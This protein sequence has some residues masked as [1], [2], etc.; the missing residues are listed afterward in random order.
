MIYIG[1]DPGKKGGYSIIDGGNVTCAP[2]DDQ[3]FALDMRTIEHSQKECMAC[4]EKVGA[5]PGQGVTSM[6]SFGKSAGYIEGVLSATLI[7]YQLVAPRKWK[8]EFGLLHGS[9]QQSIEVCRMLFPAVNLKRTDRCRVES[10]G[11]AESLLLALF[12]ARHY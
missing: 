11:L 4:V 7:P 12:A 8:A 1:V 10:D 2:W 3:Q 9:K 6:F 5:M